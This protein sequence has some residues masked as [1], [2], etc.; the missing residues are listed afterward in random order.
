MLPSK[1]TSRIRCT[2]AIGVLSSTPPYWVTFS[3]NLINSK[4]LF[5]FQQQ[6]G[7][8]GFYIR[9]VKGISVISGSFVE[10][11]ANKNRIISWS[12]KL[13]SPAE[14]FFLPLAPHCHA[15]TIS[16]KISTNPFNFMA[17][18]A[19]TTKIADIYSVS[20]EKL[21][22]VL[23]VQCIFPPPKMIKHGLLLP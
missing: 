11:S 17:T 9:R 15:A 16:R 4:L 5:I 19:C 23:Y 22:Q 3:S 10:L 1:R 7:T 6:R 12:R 8:L 20:S 14:P 21:K 2:F 13:T 18:V